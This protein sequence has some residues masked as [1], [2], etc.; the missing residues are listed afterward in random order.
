[1]CLMSACV[2]DL[3]AVCVANRYIE[4]SIYICENMYDVLAVQWSNACYSIV[5]MAICVTICC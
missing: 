2:Y 5:Y 3:A 1:M 4:L